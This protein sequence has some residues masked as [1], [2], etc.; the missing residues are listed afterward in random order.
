M[1]RPAAWRFD[2]TKKGKRGTPGSNSRQKG[3]KSTSRR[4]GLQ[5]RSGM[6]GGGAKQLGAP[7]GGRREKQREVGG[8]LSL[9]PSVPPLHLQKEAPA[10]APLH[11]CQKISGRGQRSAAGRVT[12]SSQLH[13]A[14]LDHNCSWQAS[15]RTQRVCKSIVSVYSSYM[16]WMK[17]ISKNNTWSHVWIMFLMAGIFSC[18]RHQVGVGSWCEKL[19]FS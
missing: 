12:D 13:A 2:A 14:A 9:P 7:T 11:G 10:A 5:R 19:V 8:T 16:Y 15:D 6:N 18:L 1:N 17:M 4:S 3:T